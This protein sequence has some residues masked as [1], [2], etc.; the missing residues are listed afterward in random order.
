MTVFDLVRRARPV[1]L[2]APLLLLVRGA[3]S[4]QA[5][6]TTLYS[7]IEGPRTVS[8]IDSHAVGRADD[9]SYRTA[10]AFKPT[11]SGTAHLLSMRGRCVVPYPTGTACANVGQVSL[12]SDAGGKPAGA[13]LGTMGFYLLE[14]TQ[15]S[16]RIKI[17][18]NPT[19]GTFRLKV[20]ADG[21]TRTTEPI[22]FNAQHD[23]RGLD[24]TVS[25]RLHQINFHPGF[26]TSGRFPEDPLFL[27][28]EGTIAVTDVQLTGGTNPSI[29]VTQPRIEEECG[30]L[31]PAP[32][33]EAGRK[34]WAVMTAEDGVGW[35][36][37]TND[38]GEVLQSVDGGAW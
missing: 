8:G 6:L 25:W 5:S 28:F 26:M 16:W 21:V 36:D 31:S 24:T 38:T 13:P 23:A 1:L 34:Y 35:D 30:R 7:N 27:R 33:L 9:R 22:A 17:N 18:G 2:I 11:K 20:T 15:G 14:D 37:W 29:D 3:G 32:Q 12:Y 4:A 19:G 10:M